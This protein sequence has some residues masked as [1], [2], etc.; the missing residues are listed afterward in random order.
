[1]LSTGIGYSSMKK[2]NVRFGLFL[3]LL[4]IL[5]TLLFKTGHARLILDVSYRWP[6]SPLIIKS[7]SVL[8]NCC[9]HKCYSDFL[10]VQFRN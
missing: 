3:Q 2:K 6:S 5:T 9:L 10:L 8:H 4:F 1:M 7:D